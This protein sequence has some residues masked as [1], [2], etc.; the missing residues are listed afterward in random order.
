MQ[1]MRSRLGI[2]LHGQWMQRW[3]PSEQA[4]LGTDDDEAIAKRTGRTVGGVRIQHEKLG[5]PR[6]PKPGGFL[7]WNST[8]LALLGT[9]TDDV[10]AK[11][12]GRTRRAVQLMRHRLGIPRK[13]DRP[14]AK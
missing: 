8:E 2:F 10:I 1:S 11:R 14:R 13:Q 7:Q 9:A 6:K 3:T 12:I 4:S 5:I